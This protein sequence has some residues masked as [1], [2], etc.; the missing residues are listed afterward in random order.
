MEPRRHDRRLLAPLDRRRPSGM[1]PN[2]PCHGISVP[3]VVDGCWG[4]CDREVSVTDI[5][6]G[7]GS[8]FNNEPGVPTAPTVE[9]NDILLRC[10]GV[11]E[12]ICGEGLTPW[13]AGSYPDPDDLYLD[14]SHLLGIDTP[15]AELTSAPQPEHVSDCTSSN[16]DAAQE[17][18][19]GS[20]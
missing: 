14:L 5:V 2:L 10:Y 7:K 3:V 19:P 6:V 9:V 4:V 20:T 13:P 8:V 17:P 16:T 11:L 12:W 15:W 1:A 18:T